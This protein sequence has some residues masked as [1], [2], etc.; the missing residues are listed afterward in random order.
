[1]APILIAITATC[2]LVLLATSYVL[3]YQVGKRAGMNQAYNSGMQHDP[4]AGPEVLPDDIAAPY[5]RG[6]E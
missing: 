3:A 1:L 5:G 6:G 2:V 4:I